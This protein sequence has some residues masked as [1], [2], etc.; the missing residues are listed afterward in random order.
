V[1]LWGGE[2]TVTMR[3]GGQGGRNLT[4]A[5]TALDFVR[6]GEEILSLASDGHDH[7]AY[8][9]AICDIITKKAATNVSAGL[10]K[11]LAE[12]NTYPLFEKV[13]NYLVT[14]V[15][16]SNVSDLIVALKMDKE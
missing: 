8:A 3:G 7:G 14:G 16:G 10:K 2:T 9:G 11:Y 4:V 6:E 15:T 1:L 12:N 13:G 5:A